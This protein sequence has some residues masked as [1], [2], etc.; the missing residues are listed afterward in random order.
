M[1]HGADPAEAVMNEAY[2]LA[3]IHGC[4]EIPHSFKSKVL[5]F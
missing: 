3:G 1:T 4:L 2:I 5:L